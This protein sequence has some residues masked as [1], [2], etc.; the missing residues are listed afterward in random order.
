VIPLVSREVQLA[1]ATSL[2]NAS[3]RS[4]LA[5]LLHALN[6]PL[7]GLQCSM[8]VALASPRT[9]EQYAQ[10]LR[11]GLEL[12][13]RMRTLVEA[14]REVADGESEHAEETETADLKIVVRE[15]LDELWPAAEVNGVRITLDC[16]SDFSL[17]AGVGGR[18]LSSLIFRTVEAVLSLAERGSAL[19]VAIGSG[20]DSAADGVRFR[21]GWH[22]G[23]PSAEFSRPELGL[24]VA[25]AGWERRDAKWGRER[26]GNLETVTV[27]LPSISVS[28]RNS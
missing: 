7:T 8:E 4:P 5:R 28:N 11:E 21:V 1:N 12:T 20:G 10:G 17:L 16:S 24:L 25:Q 14:I 26:A 19:E 18:R 9:L 2:A 13:A 6:Q 22:A 27:S 15:V 3:I 23:L